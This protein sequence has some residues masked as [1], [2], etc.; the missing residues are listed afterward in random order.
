MASKRSL[1]YE[2]SVFI[3]CPFDPPYKPL[4]DAAVFAV[5]D[6]GFIPRCAL[7]KSDSGT[8][9]IEKI[10]RIIEDCKFGI[11]DISRTELDPDHRLPRFNMPFELG[12][13]L[14]ARHFGNGAQH[15]KECMIV[16]TESQRYQ[17]FISDISG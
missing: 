14:G 5:L 1:D 8:V 11:H 4:L 17:E 2:R 3:N 16:D 7:E 9:R 13:F 6:C 15:A 12:I 10:F